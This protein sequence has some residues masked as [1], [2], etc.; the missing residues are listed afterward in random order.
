MLLTSLRL[1]SSHLN[2]HKFYNHSEYTINAM[3][4]Y[5]SEIWINEHFWACC[6]LLKLL[7]WEFLPEG[8]FRTYSVKKVFLGILLN[9]QEN[10]CARDSF[11]NKVPGL[12]PTPVNFMKFLRTTF[13]TEHLRWLLLSFWMVVTQS[14]ILTFQNNLF[15]VLQWKP[16]KNDENCFLFHLKNSFR[17]QNI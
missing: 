15:C 3:C 10:T 6:P 2:K 9:S 4:S 13:F 5:R 16:F 11:L 17:F 7:G 8:V 1:K 12:R 14:R